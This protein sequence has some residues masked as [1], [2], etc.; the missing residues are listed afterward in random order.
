MLIQSHKVPAWIEGEIRMLQE[1][2][3]TFNTEKLRE[4]RANPK[5][6]NV[7]IYHHSDGS[8]LYYCDQTRQYLSWQEIIDQATQKI[9]CGQYLFTAV[10]EYKSGICFTGSKHRPQMEVVK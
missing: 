9:G 7:D 5:G 10:L 3:N 1:Y 6:V 8:A 2:T 4:R